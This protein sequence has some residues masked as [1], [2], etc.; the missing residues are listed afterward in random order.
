VEVSSFSIR[1]RNDRTRTYVIV[2]QQVSDR[3]RAHIP[4]ALWTPPKSPA[5]SVAYGAHTSVTDLSFPRG[6]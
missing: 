4:C 1:N 3:A 5:R 2:R 6:L